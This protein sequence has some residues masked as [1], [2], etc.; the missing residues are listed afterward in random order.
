MPNHDVESQIERHHSKMLKEYTDLL[1]CLETEMNQ[2]EQ[3]QL[4][5][6]RIEEETILSAEEKEAH[7]TFLNKVEALNERMNTL[8][9]MSKHLKVL[10]ELGQTFSKT[11][12]KEEIYQKTFDL[13]SQVMGADAFLIAFYHEGDEFIQ[14][15]CLIDNGVVYEGRKVP[16]GEGYI[17]KVIKSKSTLHLKTDTELNSQ[18]YVRWGNPEKNTS[19]ALFV[20]MILGD[21]IKGVISAQSYHEFAYREEHEELL[22][23]IGIQACS[24]IETANLYDKVYEMTLKDELTGIKNSRAF[25]Q[26]LENHILQTSGNQTLALIMLDSDNLKMANDQCGHHAGD[27]LI[28]SVAQ[29]LQH[30]LG[31]GEAAY[32]YAGD[33]FMIIA[34]NC[35]MIEAEAK[36][37]LIQRYLAEHPIYCEGREIT[38]SVS[39]GIAAYPSHALRADDLKR[40]ADEALYESKNAGK[41]CITVYAKE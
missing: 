16:F 17:S 36:A 7:I 12:D 9:W 27:M 35:S 11:F 13:V 33:E 6:Q 32:R 31:E 1:E 37:S 30:Q 28:R 3:I 41:N 8:R 14:L 5:Y 34:P 21:H 4:F 38:A 18:G 19:T 25:H 2:S 39:I 22:R 29:A 26:D 10:H 40:I 23:I 20:P 24:A 15:P